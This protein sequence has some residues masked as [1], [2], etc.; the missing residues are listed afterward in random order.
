MLN[1]SDLKNGTNIQIENEPYTVIKS[2]HT[3]MGRGGATVRVKVKN[4]I[5]G[6]ILEKAYKQ[7]DRLEEPDLNRTKAQFLYPQANGY[8]FMDNESYEQFSLPKETLGQKAQLLKEGQDVDVLNFQ[9]KPV[10]IQLPSKIELQV[11]SA[12]PGVRGDTAQG[13]VTKT[14]TLETGLE[15]QAPLFIKQGDIIRVNTETLEYVERV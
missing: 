11:K 4:L 8:F 3:H 7:A 6:K 15:I 12:P 10:T 5:T 2:E 1:I 13:S 9:N 14:V